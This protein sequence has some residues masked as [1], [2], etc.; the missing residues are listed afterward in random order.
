M[1]IV[2]H[3][4]LESLE[5]LENMYVALVPE[6]DGIVWQYPD[7]LSVMRAVALGE[8]KPE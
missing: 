4:S 8:F 1:W 5:P 3:A 2:H 7:W 6:D